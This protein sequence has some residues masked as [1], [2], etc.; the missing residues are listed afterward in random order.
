MCVTEGVEC[1]EYDS[2]CMKEAALE[3]SMVNVTN[4]VALFCLGSNYQ[5]LHKIILQCNT[6]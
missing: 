2:K 1:N 4:G 6:K 3:I 5:L